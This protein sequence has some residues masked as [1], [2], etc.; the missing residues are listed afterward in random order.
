MSEQQTWLTNSHGFNIDVKHTSQNFM[1]CNHLICADKVLLTGGP[2][3]PQSSDVTSD[4]EADIIS[5]LCLPSSYLEIF[6]SE[7]N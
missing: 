7:S 3:G 6:A 4:L 5:L 2:G 1:E